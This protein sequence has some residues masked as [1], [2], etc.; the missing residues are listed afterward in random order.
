MKTELK[1][2]SV[3]GYYDDDGEL[4]DDTPTHVICEGHVDA[5][6]FNQAFQNEG[7]SD[8]G[9]W[10]DKDLKHTYAVLVNDM[11]YWDRKPDEPNAFKA[12]VTTWD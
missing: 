1:T 8:P 3:G 7:W 2:N 11:W 10:T 6:T 5:E 4:I 9:T 12:T